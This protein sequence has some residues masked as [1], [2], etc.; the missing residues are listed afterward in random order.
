M[1][2]THILRAGLAALV[3]F[4]PL[5]TISVA[6]IPDAHRYWP[7]WRGPHANGISRTAT[8]PLE[9]SESKNIRWKVPVPG[10]GS[11]TPV[12]WGDRIF[13][14]TAVPAGITGDAQHAP[15]G[16]L[17]ERGMHRFVVMAVDRK[18]GRTMWERVATEQEPHEAGHF[19]NST[20]ASSSAITDGQS[21]FAYFESFGLYAYDLNGKLLWQKDLGD[22]RMR[23][24]FGEGST[25]ALYGNTLV[26]VWDHLNGQSFIAAFD[27]RDGREL[28][29]VPRE[30]IDTW[31]T[32]LV[33][34][35]NGRPQAIVPAMRRIRGYDLENGTVVWEGDGLTMNSIPSPV[36]DEEMV[37]LMSG[38][39]G[40]DLRA[41]RIA[42]ARGNIDGTSAVA[43]SFDR[44]TPYVPS[45]IL[46]DGVLYFL[47]TN[48]GILSAFDAKTGKPHYQNQRLDGLPN[49]FSSPVAAGERVYFTGR[50]GTTLVIRSGPKYEVLATN[51]LD[52]GFDASPVLVDNEI[53][54]RGYKHLYSIAEP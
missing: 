22:K 25:P 4:L 5:S 42:Q 31:A 34:E 3:A 45:P 37:Y 15:R 10:R 6:Q 9:W 18:T 47:K 33:L 30:E 7:Q 39:Q 19:E 50:E 23:N 36:Y 27:T 1:V 38:F 41:V 35:V 51:T 52:D 49:V 21:L 32:P 26:V 14:T 28:W 16:G 8:P 54:L 43:W 29:R 17:K 11:S 44:D 46:S 40:N 13:I 48:S 24:Q 2:E 12:V 53:Y 20:W